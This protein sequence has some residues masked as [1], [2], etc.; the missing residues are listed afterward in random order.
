MITKFTNLLLLA[1]V[2]ATMIIGLSAALGIMAF[3]FGI[4]SGLN[5]AVF[6]MVLSL[7]IYPLTILAFIPDM[8]RMFR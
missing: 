8:L 2:S 7:T 6:G 1:N 4:K 5:V 3:L